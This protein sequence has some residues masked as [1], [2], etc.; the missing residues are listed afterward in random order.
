MVW[1]SRHMAPKL[2]K[3]LSQC[4][5]QRSHEAAL[6]VHCSGEPHSEW[7][8]D[9]ARLRERD[10]GCG[11]RL[12][13]AKDFGVVCRA[14]EDEEVSHIVR[15][16]VRQG[17]PDHCRHAERKRKLN[18]RKGQRRKTQRQPRNDLNELQSSHS[19][20]S[21]FACKGG[22]DMVARDKRKVSPEDLPLH[23]FLLSHRLVVRYRSCALRR[24]AR[25]LLHALPAARPPAL[26]ARL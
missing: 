6:C 13:Q 10:E 26:G 24:A 22:G 21:T 8:P 23:R 19:V 15:C 9:G 2:E 20:W 17:R 1:P 12:R 14:P 7:Q 25:L 4:L 18:A 3:L 5:A 11:C 16:E